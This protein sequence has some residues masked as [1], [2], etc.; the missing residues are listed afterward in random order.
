MK[1]S[2][3][4]EAGRLKAVQVHTPAREHRKTLSWNKDQMPFDDILSL[5]EA[6]PEHDVMPGLLS[7]HGAEVYCLTDLLGKVFVDGQ[8]DTVPDTLGAEQFTW[9]AS[10][11]PVLTGVDV[12]WF[13]SKKH[14]CECVH[15]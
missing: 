5:D 12:A 11:D 7:G 6:R 10:S 13:Y 14:V 4:S 3:H 2:V 15:D 8:V 9:G 1:A